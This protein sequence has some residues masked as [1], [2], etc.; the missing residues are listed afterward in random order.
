M[1]FKKADNDTAD[2]NNRMP[3]PA[4]GTEYSYVKHTALRATTSPTAL[5]D[6]CRF[7]GDG[8]LPTGVG[9]Y[10]NDHAY[11]DPTS[12]VDAALGS[13]SSN[14]ASYTSSAKLT[15]AGSISNPST[16]KIFTNYLQWQMGIGSTAAAGVMTAETATYEYLES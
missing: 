6:T 9:V 8:A 10:V 14:Y 7:Y 1:R 12:N 4:S 2:T 13:Y 3:I 16:G 5:I 11:T 15:I